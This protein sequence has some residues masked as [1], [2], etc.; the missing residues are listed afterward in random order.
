MLIQTVGCTLV[1]TMIDENGKAIHSS[2]E[3]SGEADQYFDEKQE[4]W[5][6]EQEE[7]KRKLKEYKDRLTKERKNKKALKNEFKQ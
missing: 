5:L 3:T 6:K 7:N 4:E 2:F 1:E